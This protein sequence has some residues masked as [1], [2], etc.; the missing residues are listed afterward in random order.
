[1]FQRL[2]PVDHGLDFRA[3][4]FVLGN[5]RCALSDQGFLAALQGRIFLTQFFTLVEQ[6]NQLLFQSLQVFCG[7]FQR[8]HGDIMD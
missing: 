6:G 7:L 2:E 3:S 4:F 8:V 5:E 1:M